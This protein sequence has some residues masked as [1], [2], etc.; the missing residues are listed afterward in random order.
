MKLET[1]TYKLTGRT[2]LLGSRPANPE[3]HSRFVAAKAASLQK[4]AEEEAMLPGTPE[5]EQALQDA[6]ESG[7]TV[8]LR[9]S[10][11]E[12]V[13]PSY[14]VKGFMKSAFSTLKDQFGISGAKGKVDNL[15]FVEPEY[16][17]ILDGHGEAQT[18]PDGVC[19][20]PLR[21]ETMKGPRVA[22]QSSEQ[23]IPPWSMTFSLTLVENSGTGRSKPVTFDE[24]EEALNYGRL[25]G[26]GQWR[27]AGYGSFDWERVG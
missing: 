7:L 11:G 17:Q 10:R 22:L 1:R 9:G 8:F 21:A 26:I 2:P 5:L 6:K 16:I 24:I 4:E 3:I 15:I 20:R 18:E 12:I 13:V 27:N 14:V 19:E 23:V 25:K